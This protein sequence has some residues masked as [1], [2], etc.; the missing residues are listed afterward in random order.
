M[1]PHVDET[2]MTLAKILALRSTC[3]RSHVGCVLLNNRGHVLSTGYNGVHAGARHCTDSPC[4]GA[5]KPRGMSLEMCEA[6]HAEQNALLQC[7]DVYE[8][9]KLYTTHSPCMHCMKLLLNTSCVII[10]YDQ[11]YDADALKLWHKA[12]R[13]ATH[14]AF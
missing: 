14:Y 5:S 11:T 9:H 13:K 8:I 3:E 2:W 7:R 4:P 12:R 6:I 10:I 1:R